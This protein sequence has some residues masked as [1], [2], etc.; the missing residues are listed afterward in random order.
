MNRWKNSSLFDILA[1]CNSDG[2]IPSQIP[3]HYVNHCKNQL[4]IHQPRLETKQNVIIYDDGGLIKKE[5]T[6]INKIYLK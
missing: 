1:L 4:G 6:N 5:T 3:A 2:K